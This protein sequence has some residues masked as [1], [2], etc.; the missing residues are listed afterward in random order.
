MRDPVQAVFDTRGVGVFPVFVAGGMSVP[1]VFFGMGGTIIVRVIVAAVV[2]VCVM[3]CS[4]SAE[5]R[6]TSLSA[7]AIDPPLTEVTSFSASECY[8]W[9]DGVGDMN[10]AIRGTKQNLL[11]GKLGKQSLIISFALDEPPAGSGRNYTVRSRESRTVLASP[12]MTQRLASYA[13][14]VSTLVDD[15][16]T[17]HGSFR[18][19]T[20]LRDDPGLLSFLPRSQ[21]SVLV[22]G[23]YKAVR[24]AERGLAIRRESEMYGWGRAVK[25]KKKQSPMLG[26]P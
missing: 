19:L 24:N 22:F 7:S 6:M 13:G 5:I 11:L 1:R 16:E 23:T 3:G 26:S 2:C 10:I 18:I 4:G 12:L 17:I 9:L 14:I 20:K 8:W 25:T 15:G 21:G